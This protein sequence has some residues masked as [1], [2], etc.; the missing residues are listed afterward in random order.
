[1]LQLMS[2]LERPLRAITSD[3]S[4]PFY[5]QVEAHATKFSDTVVSM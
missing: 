1:V 4:A 5:K 2:V 3:Q